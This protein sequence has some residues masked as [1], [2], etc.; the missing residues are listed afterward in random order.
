MDMGKKLT[1]Q[2]VR[3]RIENLK[4]EINRHRYL[5]H[6][7]DQQEISDAALDSL[8]KEL[9]QLEYQFPEFVTSD[10][11]TQRIGGKA[12]AEFTK[13]RHAVPMLSFNDVFSE[14]DF[15][16]WVERISKLVPEVLR[17]GFFLELKIDGLAVSLEYNNGLFSV[18]STR[19]DG[20][21]GE[22]VTHNLKTIEAIPLG[23]RTSKEVAVDLAKEG[24]HQLAKQLRKGFPRH[25]EVR[26]EVFLG[27]KEFAAINREQKKHSQSLYANP[28]N[29]AAGSIRQ[30]DPKVAASRNLDSFAYDLVTDLGQKT[31]E[32]T[33]AL[34]RALGFKT[35]THNRF[36]KNPH[37]VV[38]FRNSWEKNRDGLPYEIDG[39]VVLINDNSAFRRLGVVGKAPRGAIAYK[40][41]LREAETVV[42]KIN[43]FVGRTGVLT[44]VAKLRPV[45]IGGV[46]VTH[47]TL[48]NFD[49]LKKLD[50]REG[51]TV[52]VGRA[53]DVIPQVVRVLPRL[54]LG[55]AKAA[56]PPR[57]CPQ[58]GTATVREGGFVRCPNKECPA[59]QREKLYF[60]ASRA[61]FD[62]AGLGPETIDKLVDFGFVKDIAD[63]FTLTEQNIRELEGFASISAQKLIAAIR[64]KKKIPMARLVGALGLLDVGEETARVLAE[65]FGTLRKL[66]QTNKEDLREIP[67]IGPTVAHSIVSWFKDSHNRELLKKLK[68]VGVEAQAPKVSRKANK[69]F[70]GKTIVFTGELRSLTRDEAKNL[71]REHG[72]KVL[73][74]PTAATSFVVAGENPGSKYDRA[75]NLGVEIIKEGEFL[76]RLKRR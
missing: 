61:A 70:S 16:S 3:E 26:G 4:K 71:A 7:L 62:I 55:G 28:R 58:C 73:E 12:R 69:T 23:L 39:I 65:R 72:A 30:L 10:S 76:R 24:F 51:D 9:E 52:I 63:F 40:F 33:H 34:L 66:V 37:D 56:P 74:S 43:I 53:G 44:P 50:I 6:V 64:E 59:L 32:E 15:F 57:R 47:A 31:H 2:R 18:G 42:E 22:D 11:P 45:S 5:Y 49:Q 29:I 41:E 48:H 20:V 60:A 36:A 17:E 13:V 27:K 35:N 1:K 46:T 14:G 21:V 54:R 25:L 75:K 68:R 19:G 67:D 38:S 8:K